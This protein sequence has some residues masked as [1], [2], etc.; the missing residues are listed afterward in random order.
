M[1]L[2]GD[3]PHFHSLHPPFAIC[4]L[5]RPLLLIHG[6][7]SPFSSR[8][9]HLSHLGSSGVLTWCLLSLCDNSVIHPFLYSPGTVAPGPRLSPCPSLSR[10]AQ[11]SLSNSPNSPPPR[12]PKL[13][14]QT[15]SP[16]PFPISPY[17]PP[18]LRRLFPRDIS[19]VFV[20]VIVSSLV[21]I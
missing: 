12:A 21:A 19:G 7:L 8:P 15:S 2:A 20:A 6:I 9:G 11:P 1:D 18:T 3:K 10:S 5:S 13:H 4:R 16:H 17:F 14:K